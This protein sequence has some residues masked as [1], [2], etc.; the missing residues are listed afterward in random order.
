LYEIFSFIAATQDKRW[1]KGMKNKPL[2]KSVNNMQ[3]IGEKWKNS[4]ELFV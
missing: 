3:K 2:Y 1:S 4:A